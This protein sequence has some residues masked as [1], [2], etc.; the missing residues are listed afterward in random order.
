MP[1]ARTQPTILFSLAL[2][3][4]ICVVALLAP[5]ARARPRPVR[6]VVLA[7]P[8]LSADQMEVI[9][10]IV[11]DTFPRPKHD[12]LALA[13]CLDVQLGPAGDEG[14][15][16]PRPLPRR[17]ARKRGAREPLAPSV[18]GAPPD[19][20]ARLARPWRLVA[21]ALACRLDPSMPIAIGDARQTHAQLVTVH[22]PPDV[23]VGSIKIDW[24]DGHDAVAASSRDCTATRTARGFRVTCG[25]TW[26][27]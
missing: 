6:P 19:L 10:D 5:P 23:A 7:A 24:T 12:A 13:L 16:L 8:L 2:L 9:T 14:A 27:Q 1:R 17:D 15:A 22:L 11:N 4:A 20:V 21:S 3:V 26:F 18:R 25:G